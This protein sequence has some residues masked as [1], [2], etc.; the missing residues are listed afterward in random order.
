[1]SG[2]PSHSSPTLATLSGIFWGLALLP[3]LQTEP[4]LQPECDEITSKFPT[5]QRFTLQPAPRHCD[6]SPLLRFRTARKP[7]RCLNLFI[8]GWFHLCGVTV[9]QNTLEATSRGNYVP[10]AR[11]FSGPTPH[12]GENKNKSSRGLKT[13]VYGVTSPRFTEVT[14]QPAEGREEGRRSTA[15]LSSR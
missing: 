10:Q 13:L 3:A 8:P 2:P 11:A 6:I 4:E 1:M 7:G 5:A 9:T 15:G 12:T 14:G